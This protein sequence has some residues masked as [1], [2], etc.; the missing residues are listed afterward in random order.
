VVA[1]VA[2][3]VGSLGAGAGLLV[4]S[5]KLDRLAGRVDCVEAT[6]R[7]L[8]V[9]VIR[10]PSRKWVVESGRADAGRDAEHDLEV[11]TP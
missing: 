5:G 1:A 8:M 10:R 4:A 6:L 7:T 2:G 3:A 9:G 11:V